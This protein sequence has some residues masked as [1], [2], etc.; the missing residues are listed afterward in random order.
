[1]QLVVSDCIAHVPIVR[2]FETLLQ[3][4]IAMANSSEVCNLL[5]G[6]YPQPVKTRWLSRCNWLRWLLAREHLLL[7]IE[8]QRIHKSRRL[9]FQELMTEETFQKLSTYHRV[10]HPSTQPVKFFEQDHISLCDG[11]ATL[12]TLK[13][14]F[15]EQAAI[16]EA[17]CPELLEGCHSLRHE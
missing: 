8:T 2:E 13:H 3:D 12:K 9:K 16:A 7:S 15:K 6:R 10:L 14:H 17:E 4:L 1:M 11:Y 5:R